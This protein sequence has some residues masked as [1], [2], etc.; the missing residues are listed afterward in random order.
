MLN[1][2]VDYLISIENPKS[3]YVKVK[4]SFD[5]INGIAGQSGNRLI[6]VFLPSWS[7]GSYLMRE[8]ARH[9]RNFKVVS[10]SGARL[11]YSQIDKG[12]FEIDQDKVIEGKATAQKI[13]VS[14][15]VYCHE[16]T[17]RT[18]HVDVS[19]AFLH[20]PALLMGIEGVKIQHPQVEVRF[21]PLWSKV[22]TGLK[23][24][25]PSRE[26]FV[27]TAPDYDQLI[28]CPIEIGCH[29]SDGFRVQGIDH[30]V[31]FYGA[32]LP[33][34]WNLKA[35]MQKIVETISTSMGEI[36]YSKYL[37]ITHFFSSAYGGL[38]HANST[39][40]HFDG[41]KLL[42]RKS[43]LKWLSLVSHEYFHTWNIKRIR[44]RELGPFDYRNENYTRMLWLAEGLTSFMDEL[45][46]LRSGLCNLEE[47]LDM[48]KGNLKNYFNIP[49]RRYHSLED[50][51]FNAWIKLYRPDENSSNSTISYYLKGGI[52]FFILHS[53][54]QEQARGIDDLL[55]LLWQSYKKRPQQG[56]EAQEVFAMVEELGGKS[57]RER[58]EL[59][60][61]TTEEL[62]ID[63][64]F[65]S[66]GLKINY[67]VPSGAYLGLKPR[68]ESDRVFIASVVLDGPA[69]QAGLNAGDEILGIDGI[70]ILKSE[71]DDL[72]KNISPQKS[73]N[74]QIARMGHL[75]QVE[76]VAAA[77]PREIK[78]IAILDKKR[79][80]QSLGA[81]ERAGQK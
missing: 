66:L 22:A 67:E 11:F 3:H 69:F 75:Q 61:V 73:Y 2:K 35:D 39:V 65:E 47:Y 44:P 8:Y 27:Y 80:L 13:E 18:A 43:Y 26:R 14:Y 48:Q 45:Y 76:L 50:S 71:F 42:E 34:N 7:P 46:V 25:S 33:H 49:G 52:V 64:A 12:A 59:M 31:A 68:F 19:H 40:L 51:S 38:E 56:V 70:R 63:K 32:S 24:V 28:D 23:D 79:A 81:D 9:L 72:G 55:K 53:L 77:C 36:P 78:E 16:L 37:F 29:E 15:E 17:V 5:R 1:M 4:M 41:S 54:L 74:F 10:E 62:A 60:V 57:V 30:E 6:Q 21:P 58:F 20:L